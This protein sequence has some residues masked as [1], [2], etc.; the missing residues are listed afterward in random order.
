MGK[1]FN[2]IISNDIA[3][4]S[5]IFFLVAFLITT[6]VV[7]RGKKT[8]KKL[9]EEIGKPNPKE[10]EQPKKEVKFIDYNGEEI[11]KTQKL[12]TIEKTNKLIDKLVDKEESKELLKNMVFDK[13]EESD[14]S[15]INK[16]MEED[17][18]IEKVMNEEKTTPEVEKIM[19][20]ENIPAENITKE[21]KIEL[22]ENKNENIEI[23]EVEAKEQ[24]NENKEIL[25]IKED[26]QE[27]HE[28]MEFDIDQIINE[29]QN[30]IAAVEEKTNKEEK[31]TKLVDK[32]NT[33]EE[34]YDENKISRL[35]KFNK[36]TEKAIVNT[37]EEKK[38]EPK[39]ELEKV[40][41][42]MQSDLEAQKETDVV[43]MFEQE[44]EEKSIIS[45]KELL[46][47]K[48]ELMQMT[49]DERFE[50]E[51]TYED[52]YDFDLEKYI[53]ELESK[54]IVQVVENTE[55]TIDNQA[56]KEDNTEKPKK[57][58]TTDFISPVFGRVE[59]ELDYPKVHL[60]DVIKTE[61]TNEYD[62]EATMNLDPI[63]EKLQEDDAFLSAL[64]EFR[65]KLE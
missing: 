25:E 50:N 15:A 51:K 1:L 26:S 60:D 40:L 61:K 17:T 6:I 41:E 64:K 33:V 43:A 48:E 23:K 8:A 65:K 55:K 42:K 49:T 57:F 11:E 29:T 46:E 3:F 44:Q 30:N 63:R 58:V 20:E 36:A 45:Y 52:D 2:S 18:A 16:I 53:S 9:E 37:I 54:E 14:Y 32:I 34:N 12:L 5:L 39:S 21:A 22:N 35:E 19:I 4:F 31:L 7:A 47:K 27:N 28:Q 24:I 59:A 13:K 56:I 38:E 10:L 62:L